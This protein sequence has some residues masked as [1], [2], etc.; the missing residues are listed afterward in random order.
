VG[1]GQQHDDGGGG[2]GTMNTMNAVNGA[3]GMG[4]GNGNVMGINMGNL[5]QAQTQG[6]GPSCS[7]NDGGIRV[8]GNWGDDDV[9]LKVGGREK[10]PCDAGGGCEASQ[11]KAR[12]RSRSRRRAKRRE[13]ERTEARRRNRDE[14]SDSSG[15]ERR[16]RGKGGRDRERERDREEERR[17]RRRPLR[18]RM[19]WLETDFDRLD[20][21]FRDFSIKAAPRAPVDM[22]GGPMDDM[23]MGPM[24]PMGGVN[25]M[26]MDGMNDMARLGAMGG[27]MAPMGATPMSRLRRPRRPRM[28]PGAYGGDPEIGLG[29]EGMNRLGGLDDPSR[30]FRASD[31]FEGG[32]ASGPGLGMAGGMGFDDD[33]FGGAFGR[34]R[35]PP[36]GRLGR[37]PKGKGLGGRPPGR[38]REPPEFEDYCPPEMS[39]ALGRANDDDAW[40]EG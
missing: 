20:S 28:R 27:G 26:A 5:Q 17:W 33:A 14:D 1:I 37:R 32:M 9:D 19:N 31:D 38:G 2:G 35:R 25:P 4:M 15:E 3:M 11:R 13:K 16:G 30:A 39:G 23:T 24:G 7:A 22:G 34:G 21:R 29:A 40:E 6:C 36:G 10:C 18:E 8:K 12:S